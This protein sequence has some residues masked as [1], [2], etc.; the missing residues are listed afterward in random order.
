MVTEV[1]C[2][3]TAGVGWWGVWSQGGLGRKPHPHPPEA[4]TEKVPNDRK[5]P[6]V[7]QSG[8]NIPGRRNRKFRGFEVGGQE[9]CEEAG[10]GR[11]CC[12]SAEARAGSEQW[13]M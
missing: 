5:E 7:G 12:S 8:N 9:G 3:A 11:E 6:V 4:S 1:Y 10:G 2:K 13:M